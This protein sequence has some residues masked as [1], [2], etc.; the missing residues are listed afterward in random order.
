MKKMGRYNVVACGRRWGKTLMGRDL[1]A[2]V[3]LHGYPVGW[4]APQYKILADA[5][6]E[7]VEDLRPYTV[8]KSE[9]EHRLVLATGGVLEAWT[10]ENKDAG[11]SRKYARIIVD[12]AAYVPNLMDA[13]TRSLRPTLADYRGDAWFLS[14][15]A[16][17]NDFWQL[18]TRG[19]DPLQPNW[20][21]WQM[22]TSTNPYIHPDEIEAA[23]QELPERAFAEE[24]LA[25]FLEDS[26]VFRRIT[27]AANAQ[28]LNAPI[29]GHKYV[30]GVDLGKH[31]D[32]SVFAVM[33]V[34]TRSL[35]HLDRTNQI[36][37]VVQAE[38]LRSLADRFGAAKIVVESNNVGDVMLEMLRRMGLPVVPFSTTQDSKQNVIETLMLAF[39]EATLRIIDHPVLL[40]E[41][42]SFE[43]KRVANGR[44]KYGAPAGMHDDC[45]MALAIAYE[46]MRKANTIMRPVMRAAV[47]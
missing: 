3:M 43:A 14:S 23:Q 22:P 27:E 35:C 8:D 39:E 47:A 24:W 26:A 40:Q 17:R 36:E 29:P 41:L 30:I 12:E 15:P 42:R 28:W 38:R 4:F 45:V 2:L 1:A 44:L 34:T 11:R 20:A 16:G 5:W 21:S 25:E 18:W 6:R 32:Y 31:N 46:A 9:T 33:D 7:L 13:W 19:Q 10:L 37:Y